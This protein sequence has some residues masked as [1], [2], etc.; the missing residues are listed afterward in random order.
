MKNRSYILI[1]FAF[2]FLSG[3]SQ[4]IIINDTLNL[5]KG[6]Y[7]DFS[8]FK[9]NN[10]SIPVNFTVY[11][12][13][14]TYGMFDGS[15]IERYKTTC[16]KDEITQLS[17]IW[18]FCDG[19]NIY[20]NYSYY[21][22]VPFADGATFDKLT[23]GRYCYSESITYASIQG[24][25]ARFINRFAIDINTGAVIRLYNNGV[26]KNLL[27][28]DAELLNE[29]KNDEHKKEHYKYYIVEYSANHTDE[30]LK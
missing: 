6:I 21:E 27:K 10:P 20:V 26:V 24:T 16:S 1:L 19:K 5:K 14:E 9:T 7:R 17:K 3:K 23:L 18:G 4:T 28:S 13:K 30:I 12:V 29:F 22:H 25:I 2:Y 8:E 11:P 15:S